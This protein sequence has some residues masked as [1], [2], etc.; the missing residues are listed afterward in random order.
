MWRGQQLFEVLNKVTELAGDGYVA[1]GRGVIQQWRLPG[2]TRI[3]VYA[4]AEINGGYLL[5]R[6]GPD[7]RTYVA[8]APE[9]WALIEEAGG[10]AASGALPTPGAT[11]RTR[12]RRRGRESAP[13]R[14]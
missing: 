1:G 6:R 9:G 2:G 5:E 4:W 13:D 10:A 3:F 7:K 11:T 14:Q 12:P 8:L